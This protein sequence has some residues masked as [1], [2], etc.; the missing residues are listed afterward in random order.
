MFDIFFMNLFEKPMIKQVQ[1]LENIVDFKMYVG[2][3]TVDDEQ[4]KK[5]IK[6]V[7]EEKMDAIVCQWEQYDKIMSYK[8]L[9]PVY[10]V[11]F[12]GFDTS[13][14]LHMLKKDL[15]AKGLAHLK[16]VILGTYL[17]INVRLDVLEDMFDLE[18]INPPWRDDL[19]QSYFDTCAKEGY[20]VVVC[21]PKHIDMVRNSG[22]Y[23]FHDE[24]VYEYVDFSQDVKRAI[25][26]VVIGSQLQQTLDE[27]KNMLNYSFEAIC[28]LDKEGRITAY[29]EQATNMFI[30]IDEDSYNGKHFSDMVP[31]IEKDELADVLNKGKTY[32][33]RIINANNMIGMLNV[34]PNHK[35]DMSHGAVVHFTTVQQIEKMESQVKSEFYQKGHFAK[36]KIIDILGE[37]EIIVKTKKLAERF[38]KYSSNIMLYGES[39]CGKELFAQGIHN[40][41]LRSNQPFVAINCGSLPTSLLES[42]LFG[43]VEGAFTGALKKGKKGL[44]EIANKGTIFLDE[45]S[46]I[47]AQGQTRLLRVLEERCVMRVGDDKVIP[48]DVRVIAASNRNLLKLVKEGK[49]REDLYYRLN[50]LTLNIPPLRERD[51]DVVL[52]A[53]QFIENYGREYN[54][55]ILLSEE[56][57]NALLNCS[58]EG[59]VRQLKNFC[60]RLVIVADNKYIKAEEIKEQL[61]VTDMTLIDKDNGAII[62]DKPLG[63]KKSKPTSEQ[64]SIVD[65]EIKSIY[66]ALEKTEGNREKAAQI[67][68]ISKSTL[69]RKMKAYGISQKY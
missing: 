58:W 10:P 21:G 66:S 41:S 14:I 12:I 3:S 28:I 54:K 64:G 36:Y 56:A 47:D 15:K 63:I 19:S 20:Q 40:S 44:F 61:D 5:Q 46:E 6:W 38:S 39:G 29:N 51:K 11:T 31:A 57:E 53:K 1:S 8:P 25:Q 55:R 34:T 49:F 50:V 13:V 17:P 30:T 62:H 22:M 23:A 35:D 24:R 52:I 42:E 2:D 4:I 68:G 43:Y 33:S 59:N 32:Y 48:I 7:N 9:V 45:I 69:W 67:L 18:L 27:L 60:E 26:Q 65:A 37:S 16:K